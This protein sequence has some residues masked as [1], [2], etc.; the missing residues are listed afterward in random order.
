[1]LSLRVLLA[2]LFFASPLI[3]AKPGI[4]AAQDIQMPLPTCEKPPSFLSSSR[5]EIKGGLRSLPKGLLVAR[6]AH[7]YV[8]SRGFEGDLIKA[9]SYQSF[10]KSKNQS[11][12]MVVCGSAESP[13]KN[14]FSMM[15]PT[16]IDHAG[17]ANKRNVFWQFQVLADN[18]LLSSWNTRSLA[19][20][21]RED[22]EKT[23]SSLGY[24]AKVYPISHNKVEI[25][26][27]QKTLDKKQAVS[28]I[29]DLD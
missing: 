28:I 9:Q 10:L 27:S 29:Y 24:E 26:Y 7:F 5:E 1:M 22:V 15:A 25:V 8:E 3:A 13:V 17:N 18:N 14:R 6:E 4:K 2:T 23:I 11:K 12:A 16:L 20:S 19:L 21:S